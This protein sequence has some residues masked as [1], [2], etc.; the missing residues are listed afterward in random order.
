MANLAFILLFSIVHLSLVKSFVYPGHTT[1]IRA[2]Y[3]KPVFQSAYQCD[4]K[5]SLSMT[6]VTFDHNAFVPSNKLTNNLIARIKSN[7]LFCA[8][9]AII[10]KLVNPVLGGGMLAG[11]LHAITGTHHKLQLII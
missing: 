11:G 7:S 5:R 10:I 9:S 6:A 2:S 3:N 8:I 1:L 4:L